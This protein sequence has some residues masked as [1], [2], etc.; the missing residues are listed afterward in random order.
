MHPKQPCKIDEDALGS[1]G[2][3]HHKEGHACGRIP[4]EPAGSK[5]DCEC[6]LYRR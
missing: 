1:A 4:Y 6:L 5:A 2:M 3:K